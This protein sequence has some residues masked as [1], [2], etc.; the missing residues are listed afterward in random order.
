MLRLDQEVERGEPAMHAVVG[1]DDRFGR[2]G[3]KAG[4]D[5]A[6]EQPLG[7]HHPGAAG[8]DDLQRRLDRLGAVGDCGDRLRAAAFVD[9]LDPGEA[10]GDQ[11]RRV[12]RAVG[13]RRRDDGEFRHAGH[14]RRHCGH[15][16]HRRKRALAA[17]NIERHRADRREA[18]AGKGAGTHF[19]QP[20]RFR[21]L[22]F[23]EMADVVDAEADRRNH[24]VVHRIEGGVELGLRRLQACQRGYRPCR[25]RGRTAQARRR[26]RSSPLR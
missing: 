19:L 5:D 1:E 25:I 2:P 10:R 9:R 22:L 13:R 6:G 24:L 11:R 20:H 8:T 7:R 15:H 16:R 26:L 12:D 17:R 21:L 3:R 4:I 18:V 23:V 14:H